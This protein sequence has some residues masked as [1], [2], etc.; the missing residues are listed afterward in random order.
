MSALPSS[1]VGTPQRSI[2]TTPRKP[3]PTTPKTPIS[4][5]KRKRAGGDTETEMSDEDESAPELSKAALAAVGRRTSTPRSHKSARVTYKEESTDDEDEGEEEGET[6][7]EDGA[8]T[9]TIAAAGDANHAI[10]EFL[11]Y[12]GAAEKEPRELTGTSPAKKRRLMNDDT[13]SEGGVSDFAA[14]FE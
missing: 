10:D 2:A 5:S 12:D 11:N 9:P 8:A 7:V 6:R 1:A 3:A 4:G 13:D 14:G